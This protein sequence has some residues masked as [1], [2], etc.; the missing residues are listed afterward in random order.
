M[1]CRKLTHWLIVRS[2]RLQELALARR[3]EALGFSVWVPTQVRFHRIKQGAKTGKPRRNRI[4]ETPL[5]PRMLFAAIPAGLERLLAE[6][7]GYD[8]LYRPDGLSGPYMVPESQIAGFREMVDRE[9][10]I[11]RRQYQ[12]R[13]EGKRAKKT[14]KLGDP[15]AAETIMAALFGDKQIDVAEAA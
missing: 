4:W 15:G 3:I 11:L 6:L 10:A 9:N 1:G 12:R 7:E 5:I 13:Q 2:A 14:V 8:S